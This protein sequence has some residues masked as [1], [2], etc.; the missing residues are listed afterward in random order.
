MAPGYGSL[1]YLMMEAGS[2]PMVRMLLRCSSHRKEA[3]LGPVPAWPVRGLF[4]QVVLQTGAPAARRYPRPT[5][6]VT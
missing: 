3:A 4:R 5:G 1:I 6:N 2:R